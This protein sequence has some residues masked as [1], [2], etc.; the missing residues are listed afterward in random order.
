MEFKRWLDSP[1]NRTFVVLMTPPA[2]F[3]VST[4][5][6][7]FATSSVLIGLYAGTIAGFAGL[8]WAI[9][10]VTDPPEG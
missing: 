10:L 6:V 7:T 9:L 2:G 3:S 5:A 4:A 8:V 1:S